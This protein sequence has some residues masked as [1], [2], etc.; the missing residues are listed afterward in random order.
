MVRRKIS[1]SCRSPGRQNLHISAVGKGGS[2][3][4]ADLKCA[5]F[6]LI[7]NRLFQRQN[8]K[9]LPQARQK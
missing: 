9:L 7:A 1:C 6:L 5:L 4:V 8:H 2:N 3:N